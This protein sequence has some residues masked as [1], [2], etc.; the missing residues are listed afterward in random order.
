MLL[1]QIKWK[2]WPPTKLVTYIGCCDCFY[3][4]KSVILSHICKLFKV[5]GQHYYWESVDPY[6]S[7][8][9]L[10]YFYRFYQDNVCNL[11]L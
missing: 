9:E 3:Y 5:I 7:F 1:V 2:H 10:N 6:P 8:K 4:T 11:T